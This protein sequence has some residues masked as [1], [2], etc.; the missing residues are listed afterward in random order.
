[1]KTVLMF[2]RRGKVKNLLRF[3][4]L[5]ALFLYA[6]DGWAADAKVSTYTIKDAPIS[7]DSIPLVNAAD[8]S[9]TYRI[10]LGSIPVATTQIEAGTLPAVRINPRIPAALTGATPTPNADTTDLC[11]VTLNSATVT[12]GTPSGTPVNGQRM[13]WWM[14]GDGTTTLIVWNAPYRQFGT[15]LPITSTANKMIKIG[16]VYNSVSYTGHTSP[17]WDA[18]A[19][20]VEQ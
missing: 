6:Q 11:L 16:F 1:M 15:I 14:V 3:I 4:A 19:V 20:S 10:L 5:V 9:K 13:T 17:T 8:L 2:S 7:T 18:D 12:P